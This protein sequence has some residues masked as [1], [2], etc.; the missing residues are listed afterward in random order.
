MTKILL[1]TLLIAFIPAVSTAED[2]STAVPAQSLL[3]KITELH[4]F[5]LRLPLQLQK[6]AQQT[7]QEAQSPTP[8][9]ESCTLQ[10]QPH[11]KGAGL[12]YVCDSK[13]RI[14]VELTSIA[15]K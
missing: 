2:T 4:V 14:K 12:E 1:I 10:A 3:E 5:K 7:A 15:S 9:V 8:T 6:E 13:R 11:H